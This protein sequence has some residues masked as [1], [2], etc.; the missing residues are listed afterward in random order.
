MK[1]SL[2]EREVGVGRDEEREGVMEEHTRGGI[3]SGSE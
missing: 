3:T 2:R 1:L